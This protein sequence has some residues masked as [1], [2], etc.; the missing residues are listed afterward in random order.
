LGATSQARS[1][2][3]PRDS[4]AEGNDRDDESSDYLGDHVS[5]QKIHIEV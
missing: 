2:A 5:L 4:N 1:G 3:S